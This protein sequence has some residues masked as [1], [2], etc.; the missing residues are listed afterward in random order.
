MNVIE[1][2]KP[3]LA[4]R[5]VRIAL[6]LLVIALLG[7]F[8]K[9]SSIDVTLDN[10]DSEKQLVS[11][12]TPAKYLGDESLSLIGSVRAFTEA[13]VTTERSGR[14]VGV[15]V[16]LGQKIQAGTIIATLENALERAS[17]LQAEGVYDAAV[18]ASAQSGVGLNEAQNVL[19]NA[20]NSAVSTFKSSYNTVN[21]IV[22]NSIDSFFSNPNTGIIGLKI[23]GRGFTSQ[24]NTERIEY[25]VLLPT[26]QSRVNSISIDSEL[27][28]ELEYA[29]ENTAR[30]INFV[31]T[32]LAVFN[33]QGDSSRYTQAELQSLGSTYTNLRS[34]LITVQSSINAALSG[35][36]SA[37]DTV[38]RAQLSAS[39]GTTSAADAQIK[40]A[41]G[42]LRAAQAN[43]A[44]SILR[45]P[46]S[47]TVNSLSVRTGDFINAFT[48]V[49]IVA[50][51][52]ALEIVTYV[53]D[54]ELASIQKGDEVIVENEYIGRITEIAPAVD[55][56]THKTEVRIATE[57]TSI[58]NGDTVRITKD[59]VVENKSDNVVR[60]PL[61]AI[62]FE[63]ENGLVFIVIDGKLVSRPVTLGTILGNSVEIIDGLSSE[64][65]FVV[66]VRGLVVGSEVEIKQN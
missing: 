34:S 38:Q 51:N 7:L 28:A 17:V 42:S 16:K 8:N 48:P 62:K 39:G 5:Y 41:L 19:R 53:S 37:E 24:L 22:V 18:A 12:T 43:F 54:V 66:D 25:R 44:K 35:L 65:D 6:I 9:Y 27:R 23:D 49:A 40:Q 46:V 31:D 45:A 2:I 52:N 26:W 63:R 11:V 36:T 58:K 33:Q 57:G 30:T 60:V 20:K 4:R 61:T 3:F 32:F 1:R 59:I 10:S 21:G 56:N 47:G 64:E 29:K 55:V 50:N 15:N 13:T 14:V